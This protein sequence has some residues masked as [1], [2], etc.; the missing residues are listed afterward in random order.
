[1]SRLIA[2]LHPK[3]S[4]CERA[5]QWLRRRGV[6]F[7]EKDIRATPPSPAELR[8]MLAALGGKRGRLFNTS[9]LEYRALGLAAKL[10]GL[11]DAGALALLAGSGMLVKRPFLLGPGVALVGFD[12]KAWAAALAPA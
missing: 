2:Y 4:T 12:E 1:M 8:T 5:R 6:D 9:G 10:P 3:C 11:D 7:A